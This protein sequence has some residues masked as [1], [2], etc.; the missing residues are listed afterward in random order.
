MPKNPTILLSDELSKH[1]FELLDVYHGRDGDVIR[2]LEKTS[3]RVV[4]L[5]SKMPISSA[6]SREE[7]SSIAE[8]IVKKA[9]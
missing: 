8:E 1:G 4:I 6:T 3:G 7:I 9:K 5:K 2:A